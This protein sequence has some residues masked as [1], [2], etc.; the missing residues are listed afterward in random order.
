MW[1]KIVSPFKKQLIGKVE[2]FLQSNFDLNQEYK[3]VLTQTIKL[4][5]VNA[6]DSFY[7]FIMIGGSFEVTED[8]QK[9]KYEEELAKL[10]PKLCLLRQSW[11][12]YFAQRKDTVKLKKI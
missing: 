6:T 4:R 11:P 10:R 7:I 9:F 12:K 5:T 8:I 3:I 2:S 1:C